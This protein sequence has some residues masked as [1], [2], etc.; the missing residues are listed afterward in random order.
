MHTVYHRGQVNARVR[1]LGGEPP[2]VDYIAWLW[3]G[4]PAPEWPVI[5]VE[6]P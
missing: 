6:A 2:L 1:A 4:R 3:L 5:A